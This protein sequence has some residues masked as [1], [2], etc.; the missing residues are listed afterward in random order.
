MSRT[1]MVSG[2][3]DAELEL[4]AHG[5][6]ELQGTD[7]RLHLLEFG[8]LQCGEDALL[9]GRPDLEPFCD[10]DT[11]REEVVRELLVERQVE[12]YCA[13]ADIEGPVFDIGIGLEDCLKIIDRL[14]RCVDRR[15]L[16]E[17]EVNK[18]L[19]TIG[20][21]EELLLHKLHAGEGDDEQRRGRPDDPIFQMQHAIEYSMERAGE[22][23]WLTGHDFSSCR[24]E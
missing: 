1:F 3:A 13:A 17:R 9:H 23:R 12:P 21:R 6:P 24:T 5:R 14:A 18:Q 16:W 7:A 19:G 8:P 10:N 20:A 4:P 22:A 15:P 2:T 11:L